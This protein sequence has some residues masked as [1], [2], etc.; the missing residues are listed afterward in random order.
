MQIVVIFEKFTLRHNEKQSPFTHTTKKGVNN[1]LSVSTYATRL[2]VSADKL[3]FMSLSLSSE[4]GQA[5]NNSHQCRRCRYLGH[6]R[7]KISDSLITF[8]ELL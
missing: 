4:N 2:H 6:K 8:I 5:F 1:I 3:S 7:R